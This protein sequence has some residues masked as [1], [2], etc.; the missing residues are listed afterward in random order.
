MTF[1]L[2]KFVVAYAKPFNFIN[3][4]LQMGGLVVTYFIVCIHL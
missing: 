1:E 4:T 2:M 3:L